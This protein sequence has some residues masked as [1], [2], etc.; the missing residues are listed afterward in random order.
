MCIRDRYREYFYDRI[1][2]DPEFLDEVLLLKDKV[3]GCYCAPLSCH[4][5]IIKEFL[6]KL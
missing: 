2:N 1:E 6:D 3:L 4:G 5:E